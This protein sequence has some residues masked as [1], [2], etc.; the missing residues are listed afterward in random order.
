LIDTGQVEPEDIR[1]FVGYSGWGPDQ[2]T[3]E[4]KQKS[5]IL[6]KA[7]RE[8]AFNVDSATLWRDILRTMGKEYAIIANFPEDPS[9]N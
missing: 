3:D 1:F 5:W 4:L 7:K 2:L 6:S 9:M 8:Y